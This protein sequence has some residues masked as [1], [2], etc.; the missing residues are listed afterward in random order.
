[1]AEVVIQ[2][3]SATDGAR[4]QYCG[5]AAATRSV[6][7]GGPEWL[8]CDRCAEEVARLTVESGYPAYYCSMCG[9]SL[10]EAELEEVEDDRCPDCGI[11]IC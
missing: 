8:A 3:L 9:R 2:R 4:C 7:S 1:M 6:V 11:E 5:G 10:S